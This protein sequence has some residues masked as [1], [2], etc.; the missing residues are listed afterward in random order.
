MSRHSKGLRGY[1]AT[2]R[3][4][5]VWFRRKREIQQAQLGV[6]Q[7]Y[8][9][10]H[11]KF[12]EAG[13]RKVDAVL[14]GAA[15][16]AFLLLLGLVTASLETPPVALMPR[17]H[18]KCKRSVS[19]ETKTLRL[20]VS[21]LQRTEP[22]QAAYAALSPLKS[23]K[24]SLLYHFLVNNYPV[25]KNSFELGGQNGASTTSLRSLESS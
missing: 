1:E 14:S 9:R 25:S 23:L 18:L 8:L 10:V 24:N 22:S 5:A 7:K 15:F 3:K 13:G 11:R 19:L 6:Q 17:W 20:R 2:E 12:I 21:Q 16:A 4:V